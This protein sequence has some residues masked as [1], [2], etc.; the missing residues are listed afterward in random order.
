MKNAIKYYYNLN[1]QELHKTKND[2][3][4]I[5]QNQKYILYN[6]KISPEKINDII[7]LYSYITSLGL[8]CHKIVSNNKN[9]IITNINN[10]TYCLIRIVIPTRIINI[11]DIKYYMKAQVN[12]NEFEMIKRND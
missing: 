8:L 7:N 9:K 5:C 4:F 10:Q 1:I 3:S 12:I 6:V 11:E 2:F